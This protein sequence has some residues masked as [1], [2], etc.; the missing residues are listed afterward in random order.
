MA[1]FYDRNTLYKYTRDNNEDFE[2][3][4]YGI[5][6]SGDSSKASIYTANVESSEDKSKNPKPNSLNQQK[7]P[8]VFEKMLAELSNSSFGGGFGN[9][10]GRVDNPLNSTTPIPPD[11]AFDTALAFVLKTEGGFSNAK[12]DHGGATN[13]G[14][15]QK[16]YT[17]YCTEHGLGQKDVKS[18]T[19]EEVK[20]IYYNKY[21]VASG[22]D[23]IAAKDP[24]MAI[25]LFDT[26]VLYGLT[27]G[28]KL[29]NQCN[30]DPKKLIALRDQKNQ[31]IAANDKSQRNFLK[32]WNNRDDNLGQFIGVA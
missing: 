7:A 26:V 21:W 2:L 24:K 8:S 23:K 15:T 27:G 5:L 16:V 28:L 14:V 32:G 19:Q 3:I 29:Y 6:P 10:M 22:A 4:M 9:F 11:K 12:D 30:G 25:A 31:S 20:E 17:E 18:I 1:I 13:K